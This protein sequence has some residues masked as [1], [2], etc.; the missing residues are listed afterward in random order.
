MAMASERGAPAEQE[1]RQSG[2]GLAPRRPLSGPYRVAA[3][4]LLV[5]AAATLAIPDGFRR[6]I[7]KGFAAGGGDV[8]EHF[9]YLFF[10]VIVLA[11]ATA[12]RFYFVSWLGERVVA[13][14]RTECTATCSASS[15]ASSRRTARP[16][17]PRE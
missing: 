7:D 6:V 8:A 17:S 2:D 13:D 9:Q 4:A 16:R 15:P 5:A 3:A 12:V 1:A 11:L 10:I 14:V